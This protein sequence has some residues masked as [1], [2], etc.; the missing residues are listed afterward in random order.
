MSIEHSPTRQ[1]RYAFKIS[2]FC[3]AHRISRGKFY[4]LKAKG[5]APRISNIDGVQ[6]VMIEDAAAWRRERSEASAA[7]ISS[8]APKLAHAEQYPQHE[9]AE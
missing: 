1:P 4:E 5:L 7:T 9:R 6:V 8:P 3:E 2:E